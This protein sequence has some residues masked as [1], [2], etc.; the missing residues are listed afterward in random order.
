MKRPDP[1]RVRKG[2]FQRDDEH[3]TETAR[4]QI[5]D[6]DG[7][8]VESEISHSIVR[9]GGRPGQDAPPRR[10]SEETYDLIYIADTSSQD[11]AEDAKE[12][13]RGPTD[14]RH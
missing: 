11:E 6:V 7:E 2:Q 14:A 10:H 13:C 4:V 8:T 9:E 12:D 3:S 1:Q 5:I